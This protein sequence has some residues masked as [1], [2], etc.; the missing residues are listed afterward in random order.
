MLEIAA[1]IFAF[2]LF[3]FLAFLFWQLAEDSDTTILSALFGTLTMVFIF[4][5]VVS[6]LACI[7]ALLAIGDADI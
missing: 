1:S 2:A 3:L 7:G 5:A 4:C 6:C